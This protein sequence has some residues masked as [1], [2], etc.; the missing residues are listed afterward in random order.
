LIIKILNS[1]LWRPSLKVDYQDR[2]EKA[3]FNPGIIGADY[4]AF[5]IIFHL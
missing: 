4:Q 2:R 3:S 1:Q 5:H